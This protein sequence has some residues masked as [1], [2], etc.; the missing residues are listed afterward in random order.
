MCPPATAS[1]IARIVAALRRWWFVPITTPALRQ[2]ATI[3]RASA[4]SSASGFSH[5][6]CLPAAAAAS[7]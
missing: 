3:S 4:R 7:V 1:R 5:K 2:A 6:T